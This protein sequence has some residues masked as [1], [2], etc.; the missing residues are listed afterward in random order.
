MT[1]SLS[2]SSINDYLTCPKMYWYRTYNKRRAV[3]NEFIIKGNAVH[4]AIEKCDTLECANEYLANFFDNGSFISRE[5]PN[6]V[7]RCVENFYTRIL[8]HLNVTDMV[9]KS[10]RIPF[11]DTGLMLLGKM[12]RVDPVN[13]RIY[14]WKTTT[15]T[16]DKYDLQ[17]MQ[18]YIYWMAYCQLWGEKPKVYYGHLYSGQLFTIDISENMWYNEVVGIIKG[19]ASEIKSTDKDGFYP[20]LFGYRCK[21]C[22]YKGVCWQEYELGN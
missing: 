3:P 11:Y 16:P 18:F 6:D 17:D 10:F 21:N 4:H 19:V 15:Q 20:R 12:D 7:S 5:V 14:D 2:Y 9:E 8:P 1:N 13:N 22:L